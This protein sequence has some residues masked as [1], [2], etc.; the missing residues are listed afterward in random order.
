MEQVS[1]SNILNQARQAAEQGDYRRAEALAA[2]V[3]PAD[4]RR[5]AEFRHHMEACEEAI[6]AEDWRMALRT[7]ADARIALAASRCT[8]LESAVQHRF[9]Y[10]L[11][12]TGKG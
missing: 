1:E 12:R 11:R 2:S 7:L 10:V 9:Q 4:T 8:I 5:L 3:V 6:R